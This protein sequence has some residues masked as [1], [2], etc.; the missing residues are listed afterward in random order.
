MLY[1]KNSSKRECK[2]YLWNSKDSSKGKSISVIHH[3]NMVKEKNHMSIPIHVE[4]SFAT[5]NILYVKNPQHIRY[6]R[7]IA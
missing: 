2:I 5:F 6:R 4:K 3:I 1:S 7:N